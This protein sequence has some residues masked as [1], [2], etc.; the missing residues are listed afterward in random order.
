[1]TTKSTSHQIK[2]ENLGLFSFI[3]ESLLQTF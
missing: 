3:F 1:M 2:V